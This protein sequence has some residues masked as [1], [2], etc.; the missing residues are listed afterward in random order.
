MSRIESSVYSTKRSET[1]Q[2]PEIK[3]SKRPRKEKDLVVDFITYIVEDDPK[4][5]NEA[6]NSRDAPYWKEAINFEMKSI[7]INHTQVLSDLPKGSKPIGCKWIFRKKLRPDGSIE[8]YKAR[9]V[10]KD[11]LRKRNRLF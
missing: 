4:T 9:L 8:K 1:Q 10:A 5:D 2:E 6:I 11:F 7:M 3:K